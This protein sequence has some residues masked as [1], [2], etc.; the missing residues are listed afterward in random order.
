MAARKMSIADE[1]D[2]GSIP[3]PVARP[4]QPG[5]RQAIWVITKMEEIQQ[6]PDMV[7]DARDLLANMAT[8]AQKYLAYLLREGPK[9]HTEAAIFFKATPAAVEKAAKEVVDTLK[10][11]VDDA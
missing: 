3:A 9:S 1:D 4:E 6:N 7:M 10:Q 5:E 11:V 2:A 8:G